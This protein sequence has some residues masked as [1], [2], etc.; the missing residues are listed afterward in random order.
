VAAP[1]R[2]PA[3]SSHEREPRRWL[4]G[5]CALLRCLARRMTRCAAPLAGADHAEPGSAGPQSDSPTSDAYAP[6]YSTS[7]YT[8]RWARGGW[9][10]QAAGTASARVPQPCAALSAVVPPQLPSSPQQPLPQYSTPLSP[11]PRPLYRTRSGSQP[12]QRVPPRV[13]HRLL[14]GGSHP[15]EAPPSTHALLPSAGRRSGSGAY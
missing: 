14:Q 10:L 15:G 4:R 12:A 8:L 1:P 5:R 7:F 3:A 9:H 11:F 13:H 2:W 6:A